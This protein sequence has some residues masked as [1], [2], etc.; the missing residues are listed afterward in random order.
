MSLTKATKQELN[1]LSYQYDMILQK[2][3]QAILN[4]GYTNDEVPVELKRNLMERT[5]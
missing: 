3:R 2:Q 1:N 5:S 4:A